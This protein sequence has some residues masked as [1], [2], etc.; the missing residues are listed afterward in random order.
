MVES[1][2]HSDQASSSCDCA[3]CRGYCLGSSATRCLWVCI[4]GGGGCMGP[5]RGLAEVLADQ[6][7]PSLWTEL[8]AL[9][10]LAQET[11][12]TGGEPERMHR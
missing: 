11:L 3:G 6:S 9:G 5:A 1:R 2:K 4:L 8:R 7:W 12:G 10:E